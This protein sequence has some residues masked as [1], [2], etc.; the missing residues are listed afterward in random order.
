MPRFAANLTTLFPELPFLERIEAAAAA[1][2]QAAEVLWP[3]DWP[4]SAIAARWLSM[5][6]RWISRLMWVSTA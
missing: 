3:Y 2:F 4:A 6:R 1:G 5:M